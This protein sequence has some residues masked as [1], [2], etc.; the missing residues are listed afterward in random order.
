M[1]NNLGTREAENEEEE[2]GFLI[3]IPLEINEARIND[4]GLFD[5][6]ASTPPPPSTPFRHD[7]TQLLTHGSSFGSKLQ[8]RLKLVRFG[9]H[10]GSRA[11][12]ILLS[13]NFK[14]KSYTG[15]LRFRDAVIEV[16]VQPGKGDGIDAGLQNSSDSCST[17]S[18]ARKGPRIVTWH[19][20]YLEGPAKSTLENFNISIDSSAIPP[21][22]GGPAIGPSVG[23][24][25]SRER[26]KRRII[27][28][29]IE[30]EM[31]RVLEWK[32]EEN[33]TTGDGI[34]PACKFALVVKL[35]TEEEGFH[36]KMGIRAI[37]V[38]G[39]PV[40]GKNTGAIYFTKGAFMDSL[41][42]DVSAEKAWASAIDGKVSISG[43]QEIDLAGVDLT[44]L[45]SAEE[46][47]RK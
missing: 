24:S 13:V 3:E 40:L 12:L 15:V 27:H 26:V 43:A 17:N 9:V 29:T 45:T 21:A 46:M 28:G 19:P 36:V 34:P 39:I 20:D 41:A 38:A 11:C 18:A 25:M 16:Q 47:L 35:D 14:P 10:T 37:T 30:D 22:F 5:R 6:K 23:Y 2:G 8:A 1:E 31:Q 42:T 7:S 32:L 44:Q 33:K 4:L